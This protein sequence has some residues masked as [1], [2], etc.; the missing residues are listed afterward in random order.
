LSQPLKLDR[1]LIST[2][3]QQLKAERFMRALQ[4]FASSLNLELVAEGIE[5]QA[6]LE[7]VRAL[8]CQRAQ[9]YLLGRPAAVW[10]SETPD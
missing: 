4:I 5:T 6:Q 3:G 1:T 10:P 7:A 2:L 9:G 8:G